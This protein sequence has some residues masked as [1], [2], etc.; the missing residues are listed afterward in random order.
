VRQLQS[1]LCAEAAAIPEKER[2]DAVKRG[3]L[4]RRPNKSHRSELLLCQMKPQSRGSGS[5]RL[6][7]RSEI[8]PLLLLSRMHMDIRA[9]FKQH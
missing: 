2:K 5:H 9:W 6:S 8:I 3:A 1:A 4:Q 7:G